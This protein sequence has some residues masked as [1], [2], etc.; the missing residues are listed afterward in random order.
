MRIPTLFL[1]SALFLL[2]TLNAQTA[3]PQGTKPSE[4]EVKLS[5]E[6]TRLYNARKYDEALPRAKRL[7]QVREATTGK[8]SLVVAN[9]LNTIGMIYIG[10]DQY[11]EALSYFERAL[12]ITEAA[13]GAETLSVS[14]ILDRLALINYFRS[15]YN[16]TEAQYM[17]A[18]AIRE[19]LLGP[20]NIEVLNSYSR[21][22][23]FYQTR[24]QY[25]KAETYLQRIITVKESA[26]GSSNSLAETIYQYACLKRK[27]DE[28]KEAEQL[29]ARASGL[30]DTAELGVPSAFPID[31]GFVNGR[32]LDLPKPSYPEEAK[33]VRENGKVLVQVL[34]NEEGKVIRACAHS[35]PSVFWRVAEGAAYRSVFTPTTIEGKPVKVTGSITY[36]FVAN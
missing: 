34:I 16:K 15:D 28:R 2:L 25:K 9:A 6:V 13:Q 7:L 22:A 17:R 35:G 12:K 24:R 3:L 11:L 21:L 26:T 32:A 5:A 31:V 1:I 14:Q 18:L 19:K 29:E 36:N 27:M 10:R 8:E 30:L 20:T 4:D 33:V 23:D